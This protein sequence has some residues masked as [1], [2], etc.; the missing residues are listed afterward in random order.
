MRFD[1]KLS[2]T[3]RFEMDFHILIS[4]LRELLY[5]SVIMNIIW[6]SRAELDTNLIISYNQSVNDVM[7]HC[8]FLV[9][10]LQK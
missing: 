4:P 3:K 6:N 10:T 7:I 5:A 8:P 2:T 1:E 9:E